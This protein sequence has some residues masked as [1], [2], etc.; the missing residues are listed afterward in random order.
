[1]NRR[2]LLTGASTLALTGCSGSSWPS[3]K[4]IAMVAADADIVLQAVQNV[5]T[6]LTRANVPGL[7]TGTI[8]AIQ[9][10]V[11]GIRAAVIG[12]RSA[13]PT[14]EPASVADKIGAIAGYL[15]NVT[16]AIATIAFVPPA[17]AAYLNAAT[18]L[19]PVLAA[20]AQITVNVIQPPPP[21]VP[22]ADPNAARAVA[23]TPAI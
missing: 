21:P 4:T 23:T 15:N 1:M 16:A 5:L 19:I 18:I 17:V 6:S 14:A 11:A 3:S 2:S 13:A 8:T 20:A 22:I 9:D 10:A 12:I 7:G